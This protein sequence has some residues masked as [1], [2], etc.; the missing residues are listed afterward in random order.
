MLDAETPMQT[1]CGVLREGVIGLAVRHHQ[2]RGQRGI[3][4]AHGPDVQVVHP[5]HAK[6]GFE[7]G[8]HRMQIDV[9]GN[10]V[11]QQVPSTITA[12]MTRR[13]TGS[14]QAQPNPRARPPASTTPAETSASAA[15]CR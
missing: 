9:L 10:A 6:L 13:V 11:E 14:S 8:L 2:V 5:L 15:M 1:F 3:G 4:T 7:Q 12:G